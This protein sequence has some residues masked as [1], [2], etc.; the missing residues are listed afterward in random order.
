MQIAR[1]N[2]F[3]SNFTELKLCVLLFVRLVIKD[4]TLKYNLFSMLI[5]RLMHAN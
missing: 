4:I 5:H 3:I 2:N 1:P